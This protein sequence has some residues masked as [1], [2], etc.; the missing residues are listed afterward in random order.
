MTVRVGVNGFGRIG[1]NFFRAVAAQKALGTTDIEIVAVND[2][3]DNATL[4]HLLKFDSILGRYDADI[5]ADGD[6]IRVGDQ[7]ITALEVREGPAA[8]PWGDL[9]VD[10]VIESTGI[11]TAR[12]KAKGHLDS[13]AKKVI[14]SAPAA[15]ADIT[16]VMG[17]NDDKYDGSQDVISNASCTTNCLG[18]LAKVVNDEFGIVSGL[19]TTV[20]AYTQDQN[21]QDGPHKDLRRARAAAINVVPTSTGAAKAIGLVLPELAG[22][23]DGY[24]LRVPIPTG[25]VT[26]LTVELKRKAGADEINAAM[27]AAAEGSLKGI[28]K[29]YDAPIVSSDI[30]TDPASSIFDAGLTKVIGDQAKVVSWYDNEWGYS[31]RLVDLTDLVGKSL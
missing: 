17:V 13:G 15:D 23:L 12:D 6:T 11:F 7:S 28:L 9:G 29:Y 14:I 22:K 8:L 2:L 5:M 26:D 30:V 19:M 24:A 21:L 1:R 25:S 3:T 20:H 10:V 16:I 27:K 18:P 4:A 31:N